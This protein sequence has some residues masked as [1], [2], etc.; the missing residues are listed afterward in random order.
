MRKVL[1]KVRGNVV[2]SKNLRVKETQGGILGFR[3]EGSASEAAVKGASE[4]FGN[5]LMAE[6]L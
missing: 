4:I 2:I 1:D 6:R 5:K 3:L